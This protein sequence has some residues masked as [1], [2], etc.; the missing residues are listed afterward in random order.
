MNFIYFVEKAS[1]WLSN[2][3]I[4]SLIFCSLF[5]FFKTREIYNLTEN[6]KLKYFRNILLFF[7]INYVLLFFNDFIIYKFFK[8]IPESI[9]AIL[10]GA[11][12]F[13]QTSLLLN[14]IMFF[15]YRNLLKYLISKDYFL[16]LIAF[17]TSALAMR[18]V[19][20]GIIFYILM[21]IVIL[22]F[23]IVLISS[24]KNGLYLKGQKKSM[25]IIY[26]IIFG[27]GIISLI[28]DFFSWIFPVFGFIGYA[29][30]YSLF[31]F[32]VIKFANATYQRKSKDEKKK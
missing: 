14:L 28:F 3:F 5:L 1:P 27:H 20:M 9:Q 15:F 22:V 6:K 12:V 21:A 23:I 18:F 10:L 24:P 30:I 31:I 32:L 29:I 2:I 16:Y 19:F 8:I 7:S 26:L 4:I 11:V 13:V 25:Y 17:L